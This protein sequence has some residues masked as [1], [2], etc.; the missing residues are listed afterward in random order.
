MPIF[1]LVFL[2]MSHSTTL[3][4]VGA[5]ASW[6]SMVTDTPCILNMDILPCT[7]FQIP[8][9]VD[10]TVVQV[11]LLLRQ[12]TQIIALFKLSWSDSNYLEH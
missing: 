8:F 4:L 7:F 12:V 3:P 2:L 11:K 6:V 5:E 1:D 10:T 9:H